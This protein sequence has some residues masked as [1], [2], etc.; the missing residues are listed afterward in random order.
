M[1]GPFLLPADVAAGDY[2]EI[3]MLGAYGCAM[4]T[5]FNGFGGGAM[6]ASTSWR[7]V[8]T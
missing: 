3:G 1:A 8:A 2:I 4:R 7:W 6:P 5:G